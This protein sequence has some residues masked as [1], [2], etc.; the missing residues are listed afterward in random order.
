MGVDV[1]SPCRMVVV[2]VLMRKR[3]P[4]G[5]M[6]AAEAGHGKW[7]VVQT[8]SRAG[9]ERVAQRRGPGHSP[10]LLQRGNSDHR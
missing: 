6:G 7:P 9:R 1:Q 2:R 5:Q 8:G 4:H 10:L 3:L